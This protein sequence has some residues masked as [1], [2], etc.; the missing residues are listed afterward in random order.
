MGNI[1]KCYIIS[2]ELIK[3][4][5]YIHHPKWI[6]LYSKIPR[7]QSVGGAHD[8]ERNAPSRR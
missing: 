2:K 1:K 5:K 6:G 8:L 7:E 3:N 4:F